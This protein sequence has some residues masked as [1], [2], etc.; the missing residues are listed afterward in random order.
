MRPLKVDLFASYLTKQLPLFYSWRADPEAIATDAF[1]QDWS[2]HQDYAN[3][4]DP[5]V[6]L[7]GKNAVSS[8]SVSNSLVENPVVVSNSVGAPGG[9]PCN[10]TNP[11]RSSSDPSKARVSDEIGSTPTDHLRQSYSSQGFLQ[12][13]QALCSHHGE[14]KPTPTAVPPLLNGLV[15]VTKG[16][17]ILLQNL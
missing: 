16:V 1:M 4:P 6:S 15:D 9:L 7:R 2:Q 8:S 12:R 10:S 17:E 5:P 11:A 3:Q 13:L 14:I